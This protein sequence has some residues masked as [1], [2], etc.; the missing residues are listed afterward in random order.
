MVL[1]WTLPVTAVIWISAFF[2]FPGF[3]HPMSPSMTAAQ[4]A[5]F[6]RDPGTCPGSAPA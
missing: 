4:V 3:T 6:Y 1:L 5:A 2:L